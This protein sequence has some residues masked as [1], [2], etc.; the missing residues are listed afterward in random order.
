MSLA[1]FS[2]TTNA[3]T[4]ADAR[5]AEESGRKLARFARAKRPLSIKVQGD[6]TEE[7]VSIPASA[8]RLL[9]DILHQMAMGNAVTL[10]PV[11][12]ELTTQQAAD[13][14]SVS[15]PFVVKLIENRRLPHKMVGSHRRILFSDLMAFKTRMDSDRRKAMQELVDQAHDLDMGY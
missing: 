1:E 2:N 9:T 5:M 13:L 4:A 7:T 14:L 10:I 6:G 8:F 15:R 11:H 3:P 12:A